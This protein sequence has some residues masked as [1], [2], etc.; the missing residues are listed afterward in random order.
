MLIASDTTK[1][2][3]LPSLNYRETQLEWVQGFNYLGVYLNNKGLMQP[4]TA[5]IWGKAMSPIP[6]E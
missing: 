4:P 6:I 5:P 2:T 1:P 3:D